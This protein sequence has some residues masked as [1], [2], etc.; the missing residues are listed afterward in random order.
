MTTCPL[1]LRPIYEKRDDVVPRQDDDRSC[2]SESFGGDERT[3][4]H[5]IAIAR[6]VAKEA[7]A[8]P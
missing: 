3:E 8:A 7:K 4:C 5:A 1:C 6:L 2:R